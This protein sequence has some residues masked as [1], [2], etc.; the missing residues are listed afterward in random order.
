MQKKNI[1]NFQG[2]QHLIISNL[3]ID[4]T[5]YR[6]QLWDYSGMTNTNLTLNYK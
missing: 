2:K 1:N 4:S 6:K 3:Y 5:D